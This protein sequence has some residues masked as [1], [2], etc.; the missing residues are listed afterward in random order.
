MDRGRTIPTHVDTG[1]VLFDLIAEGAIVLDDA[2]RIA[3]MNRSAC[4]ML[5]FGLEGIVGEPLTTL[6]HPDNEGDPFAQNASLLL[7]DTLACPVP[8][9][10]RFRE[11]LLVFA[12]AT[13][14]DEIEQLK[15]ELVA[16]VSHE[17]K[18]PLSAI[19]AYAAT[20][21]ENPQ[22]YQSHREEFLGVIEGQADRLSRVVDDML[23][24]TR[25]ETSHLLRRRARV[26]VIQIV[27]QALLQ[28]SYNPMLHPITVEV[29]DAE[30]SGD[31]ERLRD[32]LRN[33]LENAI[34]YSPAG[35]SISIR[36]SQDEFASQ[37]QVQDHG[38]GIQPEDLPYIYDRFFR[39]ELD[40]EI[41]V[42]GTGLGLYI[43][44]AI[45]RAH[46]G[47]IDVS[48]TR[49]EGTTFTLRFPLR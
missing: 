37:I 16:T 4:R 36:A 45:V 21:R 28:I 26:R 43:V 29:G 14:V 1:S 42:Q 30:V 33:L 17:L 44:S 46:G 40:F 27:D 3:G 11:N 48:S 24:I 19:K 18:T 41:E 13:R 8:V 7:R 20:L 35:G 34:K 22:I 39:A 5:G 31:P 10:S 23:L 2:G 32:V 47:S 12:A 38:V 9:Q 49:G 6:L 15:N 25:V